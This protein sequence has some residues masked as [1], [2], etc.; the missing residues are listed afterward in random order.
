[1][2]L[3]PQRV[4]NIVIG[5]FISLLKMFNLEK[6]LNEQQQHFVCLGE[7]DSTMATDEQFVLG[8]IFLFLS[9]SCMKA[10]GK[11]YSELLAL[12]R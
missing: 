11:Q 3:L 4:L 6:N 8:H 10:Q 9:R 12:D 7:F 5:I 1:M 2:Y